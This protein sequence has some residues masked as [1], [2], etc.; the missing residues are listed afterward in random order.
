[1]ALVELYKPN[2][3]VVIELD[4]NK[5]KSYNKNIYIAFEVIEVENKK[6]LY[7]KL[8]DLE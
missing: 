6:A 4:N 5:S 1:M 3:L 7:K 8:Y 2:K